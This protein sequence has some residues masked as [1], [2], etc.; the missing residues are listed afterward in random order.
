VH[1]FAA[2]RLGLKLSSLLLKICSMSRR[3][4][5]FCKAMRF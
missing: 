2:Q 3:C 4:R 1:K 5:A